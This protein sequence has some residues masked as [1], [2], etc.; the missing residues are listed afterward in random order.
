MVNASIMVDDTKYHVKIEILNA[1]L[2]FWYTFLK[3]F[4][5]IFEIYKI[6]NIWK[7]L[8]RHKIINEIL[9]RAHTYIYI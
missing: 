3:S 2:W 4:D 7:I 6:E 9:T 1:E 8:S 5:M